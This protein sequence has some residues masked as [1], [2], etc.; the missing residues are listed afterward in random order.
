MNPIR[1]RMPLFL[2]LFSAILVLTLSA[3]EEDAGPLP[4][5]LPP[6]TFLQIQGSDLDTLSYRQILNWWGSDPDGSI[7]GYCISWD[8]AWVPPTDAIDCPFDSSFVFTTATTDTFLISIEGEFAERTFRVR[9]VDDDG[10][11]DPVGR[12]QL[13]RLSNFT[14]EVF[15]SNIFERPS[16]SLPAVSFAFTSRD[17]DGG[18]TVSEYRIWLDGQDP[19]LEGRTVSDTLLALSVNDFDDRYGERTVFVQAIDEA[20]T[21]SDIIEHTWTV[22]EPPNKRFLLIDNVNSG[23]PGESIE[24][25]YYRSVMD[26]IAADDYFVYDVEARGGFRSGAEVLPLF[27]L[28]EGVVWY[29]GKRNPNNDASISTNLE[30]A[31][32]GLQEYLADGGNV[33]LAFPSAVGDEAGLSPDFAEDVLGING[34]YREI[35]SGEHDVRIRSGS[36]VATPFLALGDS[37]ELSS[38]T[39]EADFLLLDSDV[40]PIFTV[41]A[42]FLDSTEYEPPQLTPAALGLQ[43]DRLE[44]R[45]GL[46]TFL[47]SRTERRG[48]DRA[49]GANFLR[50]ILE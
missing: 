11:V 32:T 24:D 1:Q 25:A 17:E 14:P 29:G 2:V 35:E 27:R 36:T 43:A 21:V 42:S 37:L 30:T 10:I 13:F 9:A 45:V 49:A 3:C 39:S 4:G 38:S 48:N 12:E 26:S 47:L 44:G 31:E 41:A 33:V 22:E 5:N 40:L 46:V 7:L 34:F 23:T 15:W 28:F 8:G 6:T 20:N 19:S 16:L 18:E 50:A